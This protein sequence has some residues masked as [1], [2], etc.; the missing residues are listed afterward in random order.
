MFHM[1]ENNRV[2]HRSQYVCVCKCVLT[3]NYGQRQQK[4][5][6]NE[7]KDAWIEEDTVCTKQNKTD[8]WRIQRLIRK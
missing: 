2:R 7:I 6:R 3:T 8:Q 1:T 4:K 5:M